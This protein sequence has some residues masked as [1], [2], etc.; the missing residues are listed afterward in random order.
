MR[1]KRF[2]GLLALVLL[3]LALLPNPKSV[4]AGDNNVHWDELY[5]AA[6]SANPRTELVPG[7]SFSFQQAEVNGTIVSTTNVQISIL[8]LAGDLTSAQIRYWNGTEQR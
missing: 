6:P 8:A 7:E 2:G 5:H 4:A 3:A 1:N